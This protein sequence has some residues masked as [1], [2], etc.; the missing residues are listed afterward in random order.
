MAEENATEVEAKN[1]LAFVLLSFQGRINRKMFWIKGVLALLMIETIAYGG[2]ALV[3]FLLL[4]EVFFQGIAFP[5]AGPGPPEI[6]KQFSQKGDGPVIGAVNADTGA[7]KVEVRMV[8]DNSTT[9]IIKRVVV[10]GRRMLVMAD[11]KPG[12]SPPSFDVDFNW[13]NYPV[14]DK[15]AEV[16]EAAKKVE[17][18]VL[19]FDILFPTLTVLLLWPWFAIAVKRYHDR[20]ESG[21]WS[22]I[23]LVPLIGPIWLLIALGLRSGTDGEN[24]FGPEPA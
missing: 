18:M 21:W 6:T 17:K 8:A 14:V 10:G 24:S 20:D 11:R 9:Q 3:A 12:D 7:A 2:M 5:D 4:G 15:A 22:L 1:S 19:V 16:E 23:G 13:M